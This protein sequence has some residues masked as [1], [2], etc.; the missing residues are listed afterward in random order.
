MQKIKIKNT[1]ECVVI[2]IEGTIGVPEQWQFEDPQQRVATYERF[3]TSLAAIEEI[4][5]PKVVVNIR[6]TGGDVGDALLIYDALRSLDAEITTRCWGYVASAATVIA[7]AA[8]EGLRELSPNSLY[9]IHRSTCSAE[10][11]AEELIQRAELLHKSDERLAEIYAE[12]SGREVSHFEELMSEGGG[13]GRWLSAAEAIEAGLADSEVESVPLTTRISEGV[14]NA[15]ERVR[16]VINR[17]GSH[18]KVEAVAETT[19]AETTEVE[20]D[21]SADPSTSTSKESE[22]EKATTPLPTTSQIEFEQQQLTLRQTK[23]SPQ[24]DPSFVEQSPLSANAL[25]YN[26]DAKRL[27]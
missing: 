20:T 7:Q 14:D 8:S 22:P 21:P 9:L 6:S 11:N 3:R 2:D 23:L 19:E 26:Y 25:A 18:L 10:G 16:G 4:G 12:R 17:I 24:D 5:A 13:E 27:R 15:I 1:Q